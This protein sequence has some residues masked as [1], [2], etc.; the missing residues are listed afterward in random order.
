M[1]K[2]NL[3]TA[4]NLGLFKMSEAI[5]VA[6]NKKFAKEMLLNFIEKYNLRTDGEFIEVSDWF[7]CSEIE[8]LAY[9]I[10][11]EGLISANFCEERGVDDALDVHYVNINC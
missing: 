7:E 3:N 9:I 8:G 10:D 4:K 11:G 5:V 1:K 2:E 6:P